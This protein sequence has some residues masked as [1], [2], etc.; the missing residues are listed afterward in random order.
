M[1]VVTFEVTEVRTSLISS[2]IFFFFNAKYAQMNQTHKTQN[3]CET[4]FANSD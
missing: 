1:A 4:C 2:E 3:L